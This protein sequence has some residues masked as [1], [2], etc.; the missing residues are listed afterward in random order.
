VKP[1]LSDANI[2]KLRVVFLRSLN[3]TATVLRR[4]ETVD[5]RGGRQVSWA[6]QGAIPCR[7]AVRN[8]R[9]DDRAR[10]DGV[11]SLGLYDFSCP[12]DADVLETDRV[13]VDGVQYDVMGPTQAVGF[14][15]GKT[16]G[17]RRIDGPS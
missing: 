1:L 9:Q 5:A 3:Q 12:H 8:E 4:T 11:R 16:F 7:L 10:A 14:K 17:V 13:Q 2:A 6:A 15:I